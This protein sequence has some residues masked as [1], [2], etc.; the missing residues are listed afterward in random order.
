[1]AGWGA[2]GWSRLEAAPLMADKKIGFEGAAVVIKGQFNAAIF[3]PHWFRDQNL[4]GSREMEEQ[5]IDLITRDLAVFRMGWLNCQVN[6]EGL[7]LSTT[8]PEEFERLRDAASGVLRILAHTPIAALG[9]N[10]DMH[11]AVDSVEKWHRI[12]DALTPKAVWE[13]SLS[14]PGL[15]NVTIWGTRPDGYDGRVQVQVEPSLRIPRAIFVSHND[16]FTLTFASSKVEVRPEAWEVTEKD[17]EP[18]SE[19]IP[20]ALKILSEEWASSLKRADHVT[21]MISKLAGT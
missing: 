11:F 14:L 5:Q 4:V 19:K 15:R 10:H 18:T 12:G 13:G 20:V 8:E 16:H 7:Q 9:L 3:T 2:T 21:D 6:A 1:M 17:L